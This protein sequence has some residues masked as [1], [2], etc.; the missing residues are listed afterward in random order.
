MGKRSRNRAGAAGAPAA[1]PRR[2]ASGPAAP[3]PPRRKGLD[4]VRRTLA[5]YLIAA[6]VL[7]VLTLLGIAILG[8]TLGPFIVLA[9]VVVAAG[10]IVRAANARLA[11][12]TLSDEDR[13]VQTL[14]G[15]LLA[16]C[17]ILASSS[18]VL[19]LVT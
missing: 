9:V 13:V 19:T 17:V 8:G 1:A 10:L 4:P 6:A 2:R 18:V 12:M 11:A 16:I 5:A 3:A 14:A 15:G 7:G